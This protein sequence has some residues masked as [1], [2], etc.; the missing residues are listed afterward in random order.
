MF[1]TLATGRIAADPVVA[2]ALATSVA[3]ATAAMQVIRV[4][5]ASYSE[6]VGS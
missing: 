4:P 6:C 5:S 1:P 2:Y 3:A